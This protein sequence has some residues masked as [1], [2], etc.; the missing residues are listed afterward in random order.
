MATKENPVKNIP[1]GLTVDQLKSNL[2]SA[3][4]TELKRRHT[5]EFEAIATEMFA[6]YGLERV[7]RL[8][9]LERKQ[10][11]LEK[12]AAELGYTLNAAE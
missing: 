12:L 7:R 9:P 3:A 10:A 5:N 1:D 11:E 4:S 8:T 6:E 2:L